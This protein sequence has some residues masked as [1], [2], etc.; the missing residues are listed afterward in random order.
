MTISLLTRGYISRIK[1]VVQLVPIAPSAAQ[2]LLVK[3]LESIVP[4]LV[5]EANGIHQSDV[6]IRTALV[7]ALADMRANPWLLDYV[8]SS[9]PRD[10]QT[11]KDYGEKSVDAAKDWFLK[12][13]V[14]VSMVPRIDE[15]RWP[16]ITISLADSQETENTLGDVHYEPVQFQSTGDWHALTDPFTPPSYNPQTGKIGL[17]TTITE[18]LKVVAGMHIIDHVGREHLILGD[19]EGFIFIQAGTIVDL[20]DAVIK[21]VKPITAVWM[22]SAAFKETYHIG[23][24]VGGEPVYLTWLHSI[25]SFALLRYR[26]AL[27]EARG[28]ERSSITSSDFQKNDTFE[29]ELVFS[30]YITVSGVVR[31]Y[32]PKAITSTIDSV[33]GEL[34]INPADKL[35][36]GQNDVGKED[37]LWIGENDILDK[38]SIG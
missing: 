10:A 16:R 8:F 25:V 27:L 9:L 4:L 18:D 30:R 26:Q 36:V 29:G 15:G 19:E 6:I 38:D 14:P 22:E 12:T 21:G 5:P 13:D 23:I 37:A 34:R 11:F 20:R 33:T 3:T 35:P 31:N 1:K 7:A 32:W 17:P 28:F 24:H 2:N